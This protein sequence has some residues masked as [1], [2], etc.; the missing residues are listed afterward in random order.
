MNN[1]Q[2]LKHLASSWSF[3]F[4]A[5]HFP[6]KPLQMKFLKCMLSK[7]KGHKL[8]KQVTEKEKIIFKMKLPCVVKTVV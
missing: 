7:S 2:F 6:Y 4:L 3:Y 8:K 5:P 1:P